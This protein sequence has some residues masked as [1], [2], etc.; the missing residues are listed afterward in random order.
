M[1]A[2]RGTIVNVYIHLGEGTGTP[3]TCVLQKQK[4]TCRTVCRGGPRMHEPVAQATRCCTHHH[5]V[6]EVDSV[7][8]KQSATVLVRIVEQLAVAIRVL[9]SI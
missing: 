8:S 6:R 3:A 7:K 1:R 2:T 9:T 4:G 5:G